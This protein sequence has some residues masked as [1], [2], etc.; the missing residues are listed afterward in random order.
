[1]A[2]ETKV[3]FP[4]MKG[5]PDKARFGGYIYVVEFNNGSL[6]VG[7]T[8]NPRARLAHH[9][10]HAKSFGI[11]CLKGWI[12]PL[13]E[14]QVSNERDLISLMNRRGGRARRREFFAGV[15]FKDAVAMAR[16]LPFTPVDSERHLRE[17][18]EARRPWLGQPQDLHDSPNTSVKVLIGQVKGFLA[19]VQ[20]D[21]ASLTTENKETYVSNTS[22]HLFA[23]MLLTTSTADLYDIVAATLTELKD[24]EDA[25]FDEHGGGDLD[26]V[27]VAFQ[28][29]ELAYDQLREEFVPAFYDEGS[30]SLA[31]EE[32]RAPKRVVPLE[33]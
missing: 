9:R 20:A 12:S 29:A 11:V 3:T 5:V 24:R 27:S 1:M 17:A 14:E 21:I 13:H 28:Y 15:Q 25:N 31:S 8:A 4:H 22:P 32:T 18:E 33:A 7:R 2:T 19:E 23:R 26:D 6:K 10:D 30:A 16:T